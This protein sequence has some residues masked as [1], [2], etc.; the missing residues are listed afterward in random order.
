[1]TVVTTAVALQEAV[2]AGVP[3]IEIHAHLD[4]TELE[5]PEGLE[6]PNILGDVDADT[7]KSIRVRRSLGILGFSTIGTRLMQP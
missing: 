4:L 7:V 2:A 6:W 1:M 3:H 5:L